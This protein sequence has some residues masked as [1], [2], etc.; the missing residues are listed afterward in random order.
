MT[1]RTKLVVALALLAAASTITIGLFSY[2]ATAQRLNAQIDTSLDSTVRAMAAEFQQHNEIRAIPPQSGLGDGAYLI[3]QQY[4]GPNGQPGRGFPAALPVGTKDKALAAS[5]G[6]PSPVF[7]NVTINGQH[8]RM[9]TASLGTGLGAVQVAR[10]LAENE[11]VLGALRNRILIA[12]G[13]VVLAGGLIGWWIAL[14]I[15]RRLTR[16]TGAAEEVAHTGRL[17]VAVPV[18]GTDEAGRLGVA[19]NEMLAALARSKEDQ[20]R[21]VQD[22]GHELRTPLTSVRTN[23]SVLRRHELSPDERV[24]VLDD[25]DSEA[26]ELTDL[27]NELV[28]LA[29]DR[30]RDEPEEEIVL[31]DIAKRVAT[32]A[33]RRSSR[34]VALDADDSTVLA[35]RQA[36]ERAMSNLVDNALKFDKGSGPIEMVVR[37]GTVTVLDRGPG[38]DESDRKHVFDRFFRAI[39]ARSEP[40]SGLG[41]S[42]VR[43]VAERHGGEVFADAR[44]GGGSAIG[45]R[46]PV[47]PAE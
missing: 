8:F 39:A 33:E 22:A 37:S 12:A 45:F 19:F 18:H 9:E 2:T 6:T 35:R 36:L 21:L 40:G 28:E 44:E 26:R 1:L 42:I 27:V 17:D 15:T 13:L 30:S 25:L 5:Q 11:K 14:Q 10:S 47:V 4:V 41:L 3:W 32:R 31:G 7:R 20:Q 24:Q 34:T 29:T 43:D 23:A 46:L 38:I 16:L